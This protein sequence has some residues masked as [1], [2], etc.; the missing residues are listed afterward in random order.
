MTMQWE[1]D[2]P[3]TQLTD[4]AAK[5]VENKLR[6]IID[7]W[8]EPILGSGVWRIQYLFSKRPLSS[9]LPG[10]MAAAEADVRWQYAEAAIT[11]DLEMLASVSPTELEDVVVHELM[12]VVLAE[13]TD[14][15][16]VHRSASPGEER[17][18]SVLSRALRN[19]YAEA[20]EEGFEAGVA[21]KRGRK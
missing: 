17:V 6:A 21:T 1:Q 7:R 19:A 15:R 13:A 12:H 20:Y 16:A 11:F 5:V 10:R 3:G 8:H 2:N 4:D 18:A 14:P 9:S